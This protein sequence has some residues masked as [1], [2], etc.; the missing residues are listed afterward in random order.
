MLYLFIVCC[1]A[2]WLLWLNDLLGGVFCLLVG[3]LVWV[4]DFV[5]LL[6]CLVC[7]VAYW[8]IVRWL[9]WFAMLGSASRCV[10]CLLGVCGLNC[11]CCR[12]CVTSVV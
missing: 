5:I 11:W 1:L 8:L 4:C 10:D 12:G 7:C 6:D 9:L 2:W 3:C